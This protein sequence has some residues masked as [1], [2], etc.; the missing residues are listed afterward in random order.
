[1]V[2][3][4]AA[5]SRSSFHPTSH[6][7]AVRQY[8]STL[9]RRHTWNDEDHPDGIEA[10]DFSDPPCS[11]KDGP[12]TVIDADRVFARASILRENAAFFIDK[13]GWKAG[14]HAGF[15]SVAHVGTKKRGRFWFPPLPKS[16]NEK[17]H[18]ACWQHNTTGC[19]P[20]QADRNRW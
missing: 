13:E 1:M 8:G 4:D 16:E 3:R 11:F 6:S 20:A 15:L 2:L 9:S 12:F 19:G 14:H 7:T 18:H 5:T 10:F 17:P